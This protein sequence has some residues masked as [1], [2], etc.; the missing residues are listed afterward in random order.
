MSSKRSSSITAVG[1]ITLYIYP[2]I[3]VVH[4]EY[5]AMFS[6]FKG[7]IKPENVLTDNLQLCDVLSNCDIISIMDDR[8]GVGGE[9]WK[10]RTAAMLHTQKT[11]C[12]VQKR[13]Y[14]P[15]PAPNYI[16]CLLASKKEEDFSIA[17]LKYM[18]IIC[19]YIVIYYIA[20]LMQA[21]RYSRTIYQ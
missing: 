15:I 17:W 11:A 19:M 12:K 4:K 18:Y 1:N 10:Q 8:Q 3:Q 5:I 6:L 13:A 16:Q 20:L 9:N 21:V 7:K 2:M 14:C